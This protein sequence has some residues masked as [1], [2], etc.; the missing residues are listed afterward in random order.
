MVALTFKCTVVMTLIDDNPYNMLK[1][2]K[3]YNY[4]IITNTT[5]L[6]KYMQ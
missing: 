3:I 4:T 6:M 1:S 2:K 5:T